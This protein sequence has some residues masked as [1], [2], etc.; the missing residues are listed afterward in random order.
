MKISVCIPTYNQ[1]PY[2]E[3]AIRS[4]S[5]QIQA[6]YEIIVS[7]DH[8]SD[9]TSEI[10]EKLS[11]EITSLKY[12]IQPENLGIAKNTDRCLRLAEGD[13]IVRLDSDDYLSH[14]YIKTLS[15]LLITHPNAGYAH[16]SVQEVDEEGRPL[17][18]RMLFRKPGFQTAS[19]ALKGAVNGYRVAA[20]IIMFRREA[21]EKVNYLSGRPNFGEDYH[22]AAAIAASGFGNVYSE[23]TL[24]FYRVWVDLS[25]ARQKRKL[26]EIDGLRRVFEDVIEP[27]Y[28]ER[29]W[30]TKM[31]RRMKKKIA[32]HQANCLGW[33]LYNK[34]EKKELL[35]EL[36]RLSSA[37]MANLTFWLYLN[38]FGKILEQYEHLTSLPKSLVKKLILRSKA[39]LASFRL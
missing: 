14:N 26:I 34:S 31:V 38:G 28:Q 36:R 18:K 10:L 25:R 1:A 13:F 24:S 29:G 8:S 12:I 33:N 22:L 23:E 16:A 15:D 11:R 9:R 17:K 19:D 3:L 32:S 21:I 30:N 5:A 37:P 2:L 27:A 7:D 39:T 6:P 20:N 4:A 35:F